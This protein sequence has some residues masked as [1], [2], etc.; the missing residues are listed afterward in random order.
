M[1]DLRR[2]L[3]TSAAL[4]CLVANGAHAQTSVFVPTATQG[5]PV[6]ALLGATDLG[7]LPKGQAITV[8]LGLQMQHASALK[9][10]VVAQANPASPLYGQFLTPAQFLQGFAPTSA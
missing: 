1:I 7:A 8:R 5:V 3:M 9:Q 4:G 6:S 10:L 2:Y